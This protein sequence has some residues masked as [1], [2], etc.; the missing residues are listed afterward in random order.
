MEPLHRKGW[1]THVE[2]SPGTGI[3][4]KTC[5]RFAVQRCGLC[6]QK[7]DIAVGTCSGGRSR[8][9]ILVC[10]SRRVGEEGSCGE[11]G[12]VLGGEGQVSREVVAHI[13]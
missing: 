2:H 7:I 6:I 5:K 10:S 1:Y 3:K 9:G 13:A 8:G 4:A 12:G 11:D